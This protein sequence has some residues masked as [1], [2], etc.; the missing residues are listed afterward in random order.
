MEH[1]L[2]SFFKNQRRDPVKVMSIRMDEMSARIYGPKSLSHGGSGAGLYYLQIP[3]TGIGKG[4][5]CR[6]SFKSSQLSEEISQELRHH[7]FGK[8]VQMIG[9]IGNSFSIKL[10]VP[11]G[12]DFSSQ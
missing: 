11:K 7:V 8:F 2:R 3:E 9:T 6:G 5:Y 12:S 1:Q 10:L 4:K